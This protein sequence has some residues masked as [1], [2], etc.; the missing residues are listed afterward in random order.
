[1]QELNRKTAK[2]AVRHPERVL[3]YGEGNFLRA[4]VDW[5]IDRMNKEA[6]FAS[7]VTVVQPITQGMAE[8]LNAQD[9]LYHL[10]LQGIKDGRT[11]S[12]LARIDCINRALNP[13][14][15]YAEYMK[16]A[17]NPALRFIISNTTEAGIV[18]D[19]QDTADLQPQRSFPGK[20]TAFLYRRLPTR[21][22]SSSAAS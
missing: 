11:V 20:L 8:L 6:G 4:F 15:Q 19:E 1:M 12:D 21:G 10:C 13:Y 17:D 9:G 16:I 18:Y 2:G 14:T 22:S 3:Q 5:M 7:G